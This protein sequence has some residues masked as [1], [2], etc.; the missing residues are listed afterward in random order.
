MKERNVNPV[1]KV[2][3]W[4]L[5]ALT[6]VCVLFGIFALRGRGN[7]A[8]SVGAEDTPSESQP[9]LQNQAVAAYK[10]YYELFMG[11]PYDEETVGQLYKSYAAQLAEAND[12]DINGILKEV[13]DLFFGRWQSITSAN[14]VAQEQ[15]TL[16][17]A[18]IDAMKD[19]E[20]ATN[21]DSALETAINE[22]D[23]SIYKNEKLKELVE[24]Y[25]AVSDERMD[26]FS[27]G[28]TAL[29]TGK[30]S[31]IAAVAL[32][33]G[34]LAAAQAEVDDIL[35]QAKI[36][37]RTLEIEGISKQEYYDS[38][39]AIKGVTSG[40]TVPEAVTSKLEEIKAAVAAAVNGDYGTTSTR[41]ALVVAWNE[42]VEAAIQTLLDGLLVKVGG[43]IVDS[44]DTC[45]PVAA[46]KQAVKEALNGA[47][48]GEIPD[49]SQCVAT[50]TAAVTEQRT[51]EKTA[52]K[53]EIDAKV[54]R[55][56][57]EKEYPEAIETTLSELVAAAKGEIDGANYNV[58]SLIVARLVGK[59][60]FLDAFADFQAWMTP[61]GGTVDFDAEIAPALQAIGTAN[62]SD[63]VDWEKNNALLTAEKNC[64]A[65]LLSD[66]VSDGS[67]DV[68]ALLTGPDG[69]GIK[70]GSV[71]SVENVKVVIDEAIVAIQGGKFLD[72]NNVLRKEFSSLGADDK[73][74]LEAA[75][76]ALAALTDEKVKAYL[77]DGA[78]AYTSFEKEIEDRINKA[79]HEAEKSRVLGELAIVINVNNVDV[80]VDALEALRD[81]AQ[82]ETYAPHTDDATRQK[83]LN[84]QKAALGTIL[85]KAQQLSAGAAK[86]DEKL[87]QYQETLQEYLASDSYSAAEKQEMQKKADEYTAQ[88]LAAVTASV[89]AAAAERALD[90]L[91][92]QAERELSEAP[93]CEVTVSGVLSSSGDYAEGYKDAALWG[94]VT[95]ESGIENGTVLT[96]EKKE[97]VSIDVEAAA[98]NGKLK[99][100]VGSG[101]SKGEMEALVDN[102]VAV[103]ALDISLA[104]GN[105]KL[106]SFTGS[107]VVTVLLP[108]ELRD[109]A[110]V[111]VCEKENGDVEV[112]DA[113]ISED[114]K[115][116]T[117][118]TDHFSEFVLLGEGPV[119]DMWWLVI[120]LT[121]I[122]G[123]ELVILLA[124]LLKKGGKKR[125]TA[126]SVLPL[127]L[128]ALV[129]PADVTYICIVLGAVAVAL[130][131]GILLAVR[132]KK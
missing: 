85:A 1:K 79:D 71:K 97:N 67:D 33:G 93:V 100:S 125:E 25:D 92:A 29:Y 52:A 30:N 31:A 10:R 113:K 126:A 56:Q 107:Y 2:I 112:F 84:D 120:T 12:T 98:K 17:D 20:Y 128:L 78:S 95:N 130:A 50:V 53:A 48:V 11:T 34:T 81:A 89:D 73:A 123:A 99:A 9:S 8:L 82:A 54:A 109:Q 122:V 110:L 127:G 90:D 118:T 19:D 40:E 22:I 86:L 24:A 111:L 4:A 6:A 37:F 59:A 36:A 91:F 96:V 64:G 104:K 7:A 72:A 115:Y 77:D 66:K 35:E 101:L 18:A 60:E 105:V 94:T 16:I 121:A 119:T 55:I 65:A 49:F 27:E 44:E 108:A 83:Y 58:Y 75:K 87:E 63:S 103:A 39:K 21:L 3:L 42:N 76:T 28:L 129:A 47:G 26:D 114:G 45:A 62:S 23:L 74:A 51:V 14:K 68:K 57:D 117:F 13:L 132:A 32:G 15:Q 131:I 80:V 38:Y 116:L 106:D 69:Y 124:V 5:V 46:A 41:Y 102:R 70:L 43:V 61:Y 88:A